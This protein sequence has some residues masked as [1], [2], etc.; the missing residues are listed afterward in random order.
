MEKI[1]TLEDLLCLKLSALYDIESEI[2]KFLPK[3]IK[4]VNNPHLKKTFEKD[5]S[6]VQEEIERIKESFELIGEKPSKTKVEGIRGIIDDTKWLTKHIKDKMALDASLVAAASY[7]EHYEV[8]G[9]T[10]AV[11]WA[12]FIG[13]EKVA[14]LLGKT[15]NS[16]RRSAKK[17]EVLA[18]EEVD[19]DVIGFSEPKKGRKY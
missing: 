1:T 2:L 15:L 17:L 5:I 16:E 12:R 14:A 9:Y 11:E 13:Q 18:R 4:S 6:E 19:K 10:S 7:I 8:A 3:L